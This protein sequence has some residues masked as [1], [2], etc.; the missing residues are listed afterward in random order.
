MSGTPT[1]AP[2][3]PPTCR[4]ELELVIPSDREHQSATS[5]HGRQV[6]YIARHVCDRRGGGLRK[7]EKLPKRTWKLPYI[8]GVSP[9]VLLLTAAPAITSACTTAVCPPLAAQIIAVA[10]SALTLS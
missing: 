10:P 6:R 1:R 2:P 4:R 3:L 5:K 7:R 9:P 8:S